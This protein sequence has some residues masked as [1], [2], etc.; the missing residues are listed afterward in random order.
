M[1]LR[2]IEIQVILSATRDIERIQHMAQQH[3][4]TQQ[5]QAAVQF[6]QE[7]EHRKKQAEAAAKA[8]QAQIRD[9]EKNPEDKQKASSRNK[10]QQDSSEN[11]QDRRPA[12]E[13][14]P[15]IID[16]LV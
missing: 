11:K 1:S 5:E 14:G 16:M 3:S 8:E 15:H 7:M 6:Q 2:P 4:R 12:D 13:D 10:R 9:L